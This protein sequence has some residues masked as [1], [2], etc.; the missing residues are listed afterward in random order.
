MKER[1]V[2]ASD[3]NYFGREFNMWYV[4]GFLVLY[5][6]GPLK[7]E[8]QRTLIY[9]IFALGMHPKPRTILRARVTNAA[10]SLCQ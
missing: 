2:E 6:E 8:R 10:A 3:S 5:S 4:L 7:S 9:G 1:F